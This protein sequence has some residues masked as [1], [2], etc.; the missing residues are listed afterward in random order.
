MQ[1]VSRHSRKSRF[2]SV[3][4]LLSRAAW[5][6]SER[7]RRIPRKDIELIEFFD[8]LIAEFRANPATLCSRN[9]F[10]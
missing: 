8:N 9:Q 6:L 4:N 3:G 5:Y 1:Y 7:K 10:A 2:E